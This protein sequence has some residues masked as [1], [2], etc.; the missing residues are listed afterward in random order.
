MGE[1]LMEGRIDG[2]KDRWREGLM[3]GRR[4]GEREK[5]G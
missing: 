3:E 2:G 5:D 1:G 4:N